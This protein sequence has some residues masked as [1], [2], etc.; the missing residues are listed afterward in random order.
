MAG[1]SLAALMAAVEPYLPIV[2]VFA[3][4]GGWPS[5]RE[6]APFIQRVELA[7]R[8]EGL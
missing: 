1:V 2:G 4:L 5:Q 8:S 6:Q 7:L 3:L